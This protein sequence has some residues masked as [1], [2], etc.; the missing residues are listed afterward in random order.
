MKIAPA[1]ESQRRFFKPLEIKQFEA[2]TA[3]PISEPPPNPEE[4]QGLPISSLPT[5]MPGP[6]LTHLTVGTTV[7]VPV[8]LSVESKAEPK[9]VKLADFLKDGAIAGGLGS[10]PLGVI[11][12]ANNANPA[13]LAAQLTSYGFTPQASDQIAS[14]ALNF[15]RSNVGHLC[16]VF[17]AGFGAGVGTAELLRPDWEWKI[18]LMVGGILGVVAVAIVALL[19]YLGVYGQSARDATKAVPAPNQA[20]TKAVEAGK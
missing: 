4:A 10:A 15:A 2:L 19:I 18:K 8:F 16:C 13:Q 12:L 11:P 17:L 5:G 3:A 1:Y 14:A 20:A 9:R 7:Y 6:S